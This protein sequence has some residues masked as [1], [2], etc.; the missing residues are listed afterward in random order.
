MTKA[1]MSLALL[2]ATMLAPKLATAQP[3]VIEE[4]APA[5]IANAVAEATKA[6]DEGGDGPFKAEMVREVSLPTHTVYRPRNLGGAA[7]R[8]PLPVIAWGNGACTNW[9]NRFRYLLTE[10]ASFGYVVVAIGPIGP[11]T[12]EWKV[13]I[14]DPKVPPTEATPGSYAAQITDAIDWAVAENQRKGSPYY[15][16]LDTHAI[17]VAGQSCGGLQAISA[18]ADHRV[19]TAL[20]LN[21]GTF[22]AGTKPLAGTGDA[23]KASLKRIHVPTIWVSGDASDIAHNNAGGDFAAFDSAP[24]IWAWH[25]GT[26]HAEHYRTPNGGLFAPVV[27]AWLDWRLKHHASQAAW[28][29]GKDCRL[30]TASGWHVQT[31]GF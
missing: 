24:G 1:V 5:N 8:A 14:G 15:H 6:A 31:K 19:K 11:H 10:V 2:A 23:I 17:A 20:V 26:G 3:A 22:P 21:S 7:A 16:R 13:Q 4:V 25:D 18:A 29:T 9:G 27:I 12:L 28:F 30:C